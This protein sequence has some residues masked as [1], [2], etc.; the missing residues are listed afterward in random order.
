MTTPVTLP[1]LTPRKVTGDPTSRPLRE[2]LEKYRTALRLDVRNLLPPKAMAPAT[3]SAMAPTT[4]PPIS[5]G[6]VF[7][8]IV[9]ALR[10]SLHYAFAA[11]ASS[12]RAPRLRKLRTFGSGQ[13]SR[14]CF[15][16]P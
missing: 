15:G 16:S 14:N 9:V 4:K 3:A 5:F 6:F 1:T 13:W 11:A 2:E 7:L 10:C 12:P 8:A